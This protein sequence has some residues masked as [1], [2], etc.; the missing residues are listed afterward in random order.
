MSATPTHVSDRLSEYCEG[1]LSQDESARIAEHLLACRTCRQAYDDVQ[2]GVR[3]ASELC[4]VEA[5]D[6]LWNG[7]AAAAAGGRVT[8]ISR[9]HSPSYRA[10]GGWRMSASITLLIVGGS[11]AAWSVAATRAARWSV[12]AVAGT[13]TIGSSRLEGRARL[14]AGDWLVTDSVSTAMV[15]VG[16]IGNAEVAPGSRL[17]LV[18]ANPADHRLAL[19]RGSIHARISAPPRLFVVETPAGTAI[20][21]GCEYTL[22]VDASGTS[23]LHVTLGWVALTDRSKQ[24]L[25]PAGAVATTRPGIGVSIPYYEDATIALRNGV[26]TLDDRPDDPIA[27]AVV[28]NE[29]RRRDA[30]TLWH[31]LPRVE[32]QARAQVVTR[33]ATLVPMPEGVSRDEVLDLDSGDLDRWLEAIEPAWSVVRQPLWMRVASG[34]WEYVRGE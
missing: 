25:V 5:P 29:A 11:A 23:R 22:D 32:G 33:L 31:I 27:L 1:Q 10:R 18:R 6:A 30:L 19:E 3:L 2:L 24:T 15:T 8:P 4:V 26:L 14:V 13:P 28:L 17:R 20:D 7:I 34:V 16:R 9:S 12:E 21:L